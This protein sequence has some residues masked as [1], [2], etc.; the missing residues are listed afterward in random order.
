MNKHQVKGMS[1]RVTGEVKQ[2]VGRLTGDT[3]LT[4][5]GHARE[6]KGKLQQGLGDAKEA[7]RHEKREA[8]TRDMARESRISR[9]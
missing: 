9:R 8:E 7:L 5:K 1:N 4:A 6:A 2:Q 3:S